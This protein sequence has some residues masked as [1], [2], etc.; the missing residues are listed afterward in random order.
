MLKDIVA[1]LRKFEGILRKKDIKLVGG[2]LKSSFLPDNVVIGPGDD[3]G[4]IKVEGSDDFFLLACD[5]IHPLLVKN[6]PYAAG[7]ASVMVNVNDIYAMGGIPVA[8]VNVIS[9]TSEEML[10]SI[11]EGMKKASIKYRVPIL[12]G[13]IH[14]DAS[15]NEV[16]V[17]VLGRA[18]KV[19]SS[20]NALAGE[21]IILA[22]DIEGRVGCKSVNSWDSTSGKDSEILL[23]QLAVMNCLAKDELVSA[24]KDV[25]MG[26]IAGTLAMLLESSKKGAA[27]DLDLIPVPVNMDL[28]K[29]LKSFLS[30]GFVLTCSKDNSKIVKSL[31]EENGIKAEKIG[32][33][34]ESRIMSLRY[35]GKSETLFDFNEDYLA[36]L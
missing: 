30:F 9:Y 31:F 22:V 17:A 3:A 27:V 13:H 29:W 8:V 5:G 15:E 4:V 11:L 19:I 28:I 20:Y 7:K 24:G 2:I 16:S 21:D 23:R 32:V 33:V 6:E 36:C 35:G 10:K 26:G 12:G 1:E 34:N 25:S 14:P 18:E